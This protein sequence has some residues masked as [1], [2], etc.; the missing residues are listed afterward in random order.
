MKHCNYCGKEVNDNMRYCNYC[1]K[2]MVNDLNKKLSLNKDVDNPNDF[3]RG[4]FIH[5][6]IE[7]DLNELMERNKGKK[8]NAVKELRDITGLGLREAKEVIDNH[9]RIDNK[10]IKKN[11]SNNKNDNQDAIAGFMVI[12]LIVA[13]SMIKLPNMS[14]ID[15][16]VLSTYSIFGIVISSILILI[17][18]IRRKVYLATENSS[19]L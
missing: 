10:Q 9:H 13:L 8:I 18:K 17:L 2:E 16:M 5:M 19:K 4:T 11:S 1:G 14:F 15:F 12:I 6:G 3:D 7:V